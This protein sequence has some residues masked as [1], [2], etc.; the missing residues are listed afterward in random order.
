M[1]TLKIREPDQ[2]QFGYL[3]EHPDIPGCVSDGETIQEGIANGREALR[4]CVDMFKESS[5][6]LPTPSI[7]AA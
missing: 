3:V 5:R 1:R 2:H 6:K 4:D 7:A